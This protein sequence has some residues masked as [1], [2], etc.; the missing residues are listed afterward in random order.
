MAWHGLVVLGGVALTCEIIVWSWARGGA[1][2]ATP[3]WPGW[4]AWLAWLAWPGLACSAGA[5]RFPGSAYRASSRQE[6][7]PNARCFRVD[8]GGGWA[9]SG[10]SGF[11]MARVRLARCGKQCDWDLEIVKSSLAPT[12]GW[13]GDP[14]VFWPGG[15]RTLPP[16]T[17]DPRWVPSGARS[18][19]TV[20]SNGVSALHAQA[21]E[22]A[23][24]GRAHSVLRCRS[25]VHPLKRTP[26]L[27]RTRPAADRTRR[28]RFADGERAWIAGR[29]MSGFDDGVTMSRAWW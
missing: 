27:E 12:V 19:V 23:R 6:Y 13:S 26:V 25:A 4:L 7:D 28:R 20:R 22:R 3:A 5:A 15:C 1:G 18:K 10:D 16:R 2:V 24:G 11:G 29:G 9:W 17:L 14:G 21:R 8:F